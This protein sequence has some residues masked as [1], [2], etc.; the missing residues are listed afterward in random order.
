M[1][2]LAT[3]E[4]TLQRDALPT[5]QQLIAKWSEAQKAARSHSTNE[6]FIFKGTRTVAFEGDIL[7]I[8]EDS[9]LDCHS[10]EKPKGK[11]KVTDRESLM[12]GGQSGMPTF[13]PGHGVESQ[14][15]RH[16]TD[17]VEDMEMPPLKKRKSYPALTTEQVQTLM[18]WINEGAVWTD[19]VVLE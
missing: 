3:I 19:G 13:T 12:E 5:G 8:L 17:Q 15:I 18:T 11:F 16:V 6:R 4:P 7:P 14:L 10:G 9:C 2:L 1:A